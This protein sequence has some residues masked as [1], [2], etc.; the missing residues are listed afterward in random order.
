MSFIAKLLETLDLFDISVVEDVCMTPMSPDSSGPVAAL[1][2]RKAVWTTLD[3]NLVVIQGS[4]FSG[5][6]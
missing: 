2:R 3:P 4:Q 1:F 6:Q 5:C